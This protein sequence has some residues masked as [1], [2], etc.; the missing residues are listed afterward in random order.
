MSSGVWQQKG[1]VWYFHQL[2]KVCLVEATQQNKM[3]SVRFKATLIFY[4]PKDKVYE[5]S[6]VRVGHH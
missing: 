2:P 5:Q 4:A 6:A 3:S 1:F